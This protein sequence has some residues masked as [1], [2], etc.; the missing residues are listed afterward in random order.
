M[1]KTKRVWQVEK[2]ML[3]KVSA[4]TAGQYVGGSG[5]VPGARGGA[6]ISQVKV[7]LRNNAGSLVPRLYLCAHSQTKVLFVH[8]L[9]SL[10]TSAQ[11][12]HGNEATPR[13]KLSLYEHEDS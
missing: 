11:V 1:L 7:E 8:F 5:G 9:I 12:K 10:S 4:G 6:R 3:K 13:W 2:E